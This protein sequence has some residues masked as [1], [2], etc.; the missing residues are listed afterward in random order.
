MTRPAVIT[1]IEALRGAL[2][3]LK[4]ADESIGFVPTMGAL[5]EGHA[6]LIDAARRDCEHVVV[7]IFVNPLQFDRRDD[8]ERYPR[9]LDAD[10][11][12]CRGLGVDFV[13]APT[14][15]EMYPTH[16]AC[17]VDVRRLGDHLCGAFR[18]GH[19]SGVATVVMKL[20]R[21]VQADRAYF[22][23]KD[24]QQLA[25]IRR[26][27]S[28]L[29]VP[30]EIVGVPTV[31]EAD[32]LALSSRNRLLSA[33][34]RAK[35]IALYNALRSVERAIA[36]GERDAAAL[37]RAA[38]ATIPADPAIRLEYL[39][40]VDPEE[41]QPASTVAGPVIVAGAMWVGTT[42]LIDNIRTS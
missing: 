8:L 29:D 35:A 27:V 32:G 42:R 20:F 14:A 36:A 24:A 6:R 34:E 7:S 23:E 19:F 39:Q 16:P 21:I 15:A 41:L 13:F 5:H 22:G 9:T 30:V 40:I 25:I 37:L 2:S 4:R 11:D 10:V 12:I 33:E 3:D 26:M 1:T 17:I 38:S 28:D 18:P 31:R